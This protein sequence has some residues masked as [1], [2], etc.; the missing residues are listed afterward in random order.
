MESIP[1][2]ILFD[3][4][5][6]LKYDDISNL[7]LTSKYIRGCK[8]NF[9][10]LHK[11]KFD[12]CLKEI[13]SIK[14]KIGNANFPCY[15]VAVG[16]CV[17]YNNTKLYCPRVSIKQEFPY[18]TRRFNNTD[19]F[20]VYNSEICIYNE[21]ECESRIESRDCLTVLFDALEGKPFQISVNN[22]SKHYGEMLTK[23]N[24]NKTMHMKRFWYN[25]KITRKPKLPNDDIVLI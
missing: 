5:N 20:Y 15:D 8:P 16:Y 14:Y 25:V 1:A 19:V 24:C 22:D 11:L 7:S 13:S 9:Q 17:I 12:N 6:R 23:E 21:Y 4:Y 3:I 18:S 2:E 10:Y